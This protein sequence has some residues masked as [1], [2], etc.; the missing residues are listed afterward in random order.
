MTKLDRT[1]QREILEELRA[2]YPERVS[3]QSHTNFSD[4]SF[5]VNLFYLNE[6]KLIDATSGKVVNAPPSIF[7][8][9]ITASGLD[10]LED[11]GGLSA[12]LKTVTVRLDE[13]SIIP[14]FEKIITASALPPEEKKS[15]AQKLK[16]LSGKVLEKLI[17]NAL[18]KGIENPDKMVMLISSWIPK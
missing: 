4:Q 1:M 3:F 13:K 7:S 10:F 15:M 17:L 18:E 6:H 12:I 16:G 11:D 2:V 8:A 9:R 14:I 5:Q